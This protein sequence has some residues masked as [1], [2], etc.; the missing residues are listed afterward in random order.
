MNI[1]SSIF[2]TECCEELGILINKYGIEVCQPSPKVLKDIA[3]QIADRDNAVR[4]AALNC[5]VAAY[6][7]VGNTVYK[8]IG[9]VMYILTSYFTLAFL[10]VTQTIL[11][12]GLFQITVLVNFL[13]SNFFS[14]GFSLK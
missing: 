1:F 14:L 7:I 10:T 13:F 12:L 11:S 2:F 3:A 4:S 8:Y 6:N 5:I 9:R